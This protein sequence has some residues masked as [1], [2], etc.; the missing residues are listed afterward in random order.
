MKIG[1]PKLRGRP[2]GRKDSKQKFMPYDKTGIKSY[3]RLYHRNGYEEGKLDFDLF[4]ALVKMNCY[5]CGSPPQ[6]VNPHRS[7]YKEFNNKGVH[8]S[9]QFWQDSFVPYN[10]ID[11][12]EP[13]DD[14][15]DVT[16]LVT[17]CKICNFLKCRLVHDQFLEHIH[18]IAKHHPQEPCQPCAN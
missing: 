13:K 4:L 17:C 8:M 3:K 2:K 18:K 16:N 7:S 15:T 14:Y 6:L 1:A 11:K 12:K 9:F 5:Y 10:G